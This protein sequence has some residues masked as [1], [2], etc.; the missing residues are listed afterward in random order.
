[1][2]FK[3]RGQKYGTAFTTCRLLGATAVSALWGPARRTW[4]NAR[5]SLCG[6][7]GTHVFACSE[8]PLSKKCAAPLFFAS[9]M[10]G[11]KRKS[12]LDRR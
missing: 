7:E 9:S 10:L 8:K 3:I 5:G 6:S 11:T 12:G 1:M 2:T 4:L